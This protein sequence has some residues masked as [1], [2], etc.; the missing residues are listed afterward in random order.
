MYLNRRVFVMPVTVHLC[1]YVVS[2]VAFVLPLLII[3]FLLVTV[4]FPGYLYLFFFKK[5]VRESKYEITKVVSLIKMAVNQPNLY[6]SS[7]F[8]IE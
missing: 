7:P 5:S 3:S 1:A 4:A 2:Y 8:K 6:V